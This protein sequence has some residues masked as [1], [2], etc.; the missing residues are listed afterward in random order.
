MEIKQ[1][2]Y[3]FLKWTEKYAG[4][5]MIYLAQGGFWLTF[6]KIFEIILGLGL[7]IVFARFLPKEVFGAYQY[8]LSLTAIIGIFSMSGINTALIRTVA[9]G[10][11]RMFWP[12]FVVRLKWAFL[13]SLTALLIAGWYGWQQNWQLALCFLIVAIFLPF[14]NSLTIFLVFWQGKKRFDL[15]NKYFIFYNLLGAGLLILTILLTKNLVLIVFTYFFAFTLAGAIFFFLTKKEAT[16]GEIEKETIPYGQHLTAMSVIG[17]LAAYLDKVILWQLVGP[18]AVAIYTF[19]E[20]PILK[21]QELLPISSLALPKLSERNVREIKKRLLEKFF[22]LFLLA[23]GLILI[24][25]SLCP[26]LFKLLFPAYLNSVFYSQTLA[27]ILIFSPFY[28]LSAA[29]TAEMRKKELYI[30]NFVTPTLK[31]LLLLT[32]IPLLG[33]W[34]IIYANLTAN[35]FNSILIFYFFKKI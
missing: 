7:M 11:E 20:R 13:G 4:T 1:K 14:I 17:S 34:G 19:A 24:Y 21:L 15:Q 33:I 2:I 35:L 12:C 3:N 10:N 8:I 23:A 31:I 29:L 30:L 6:G 32:L 28:L 25:I 16:A 9:K 5:D 27:L 18:I 22:K 26:Y